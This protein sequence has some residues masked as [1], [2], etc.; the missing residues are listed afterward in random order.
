MDEIQKKILFQFQYSYHSRI[1]YQLLTIL[2]EIR[3]QWNSDENYRLTFQK[4]N[5]CMNN[6]NSGFGLYNIHPHIK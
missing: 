1:I 3:S 4:K 5:M 6:N 2:K